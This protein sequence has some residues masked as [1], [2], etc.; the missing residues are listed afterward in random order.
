[1]AETCRTTNCHY[2]PEGADSVAT[3]K[4]CNRISFWKYPRQGCHRFYLSWVLA[5]FSLWGEP[6]LAR[7]ANV[8]TAGKVLSTRNKPQ[9]LNLVHI[10]SP[11]VAWALLFWFTLASLIQLRLVKIILYISCYWCTE[12]VMFIF[13]NLIYDSFIARLPTT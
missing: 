10:T 7:K 13:S 9:V 4:W 6:H 12:N 2:Q 1:M 3:A 11:F 5:G 8:T